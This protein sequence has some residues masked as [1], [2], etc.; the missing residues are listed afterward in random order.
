M[1]APSAMFPTRESGT[2]ESGTRESGTRESGT[3][4][5]TGDAPAAAPPMAGSDV[6]DGSATMALTWLWM[7]V[8]FGDPK[9][10]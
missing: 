1:A 2:R 3:G 4:I 6:A 9:A 8:E 10:R 7:N 5:G